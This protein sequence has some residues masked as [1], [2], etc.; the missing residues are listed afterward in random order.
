MRTL[1]LARQVRQVHWRAAQHD[2]IRTGLKKISQIFRAGNPANGGKSQTQVFRI[3]NGARLPDT[4]NGR[5]VN[6]AAQDPGLHVILTK[7]RPAI[8]MQY[9]TRNAIDE[10][11]PIS[12][13]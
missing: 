13:F 2:G 9:G 11:D 5:L 8:A 3:H 6:D 7:C 10:R 4:G 1:D 12:R